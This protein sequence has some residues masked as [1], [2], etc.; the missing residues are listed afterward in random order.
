M[1][2]LH[3]RLPVVPPICLSPEVLQQ[4]QPWRLEGIFSTPAWLGFVVDLNGP[5]ALNEQ[6]GIVGLIMTI[7][8]ARRRAVEVGEAHRCEQIGRGHAR[9]QRR[10]GMPVRELPDTPYA[11]RSLRSFSHNPRSLSWPS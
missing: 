4:A 7:P 9:K 3:A 11:A 5:V 1:A 8:D 2:L 6:G 10:T